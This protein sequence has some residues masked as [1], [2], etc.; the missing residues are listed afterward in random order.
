MTNHKDDCKAARDK[1]QADLDV[2]AAALA[3]VTKQEQ[4]EEK[5]HADAEAGFITF[6]VSSAAL[7]LV[8]KCR[9]P[10]AAVAQLGLFRILLGAAQSD[11]ETTVVDAQPKWMWRQEYQHHEQLPLAFNGTWPSWNSDLDNIPW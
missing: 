4:D 9:I 5:K 1:A 6:V 3:E 11:G 8:S 10:T 7:G 2:A